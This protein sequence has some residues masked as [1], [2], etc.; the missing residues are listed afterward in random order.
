MDDWESVADSEKAYG[1]NEEFLDSLGNNLDKLDQLEKLDKLDQLDQLENLGKLDQ[2][3]K[4]EFLGK[5]EHVNELKSIMYK[6]DDTVMTKLVNVNGNVM[7]MVSK[8]ETLKGKIDS[9][10]KKLEENSKNINTLIGRVDSIGRMLGKI[11]PAKTSSW[12]HTGYEAT[13]SSNR[14]GVTSFSSNYVGN[15]NRAQSLTSV[16]KVSG[17]DS[18]SSSRS[19]GSHKSN[20]CIGNQLSKMRNEIDKAYSVFDAFVN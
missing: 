5:L 7:N 19:G 4:L 10:E 8:V 2:L 13:P 17:N 14:S 18:D 1:D 3:E 20:D 12:H 15:G 9:L 11:T 16:K 6:M